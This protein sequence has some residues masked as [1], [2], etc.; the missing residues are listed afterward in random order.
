RCLQS[1]FGGRPSSQI[2]VR[3]RGRL[4]DRMEGARALLL[5]GR[6]AVECQRR[7][8]PPYPRSTIRAVPATTNSTLVQPSDPE[9]LGGAER[10]QILGTSDGAQSD[11]LRRAGQLLRV[12]HVRRSVSLRRAIL[13]RFHLS[14]IDRAQENRA[15]RT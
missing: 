10:T 7:A 15:S 6:A 13:A 9:S 8:K 4:A 11:V 3:A 14:T 5:R 1:V 12:R 2:D